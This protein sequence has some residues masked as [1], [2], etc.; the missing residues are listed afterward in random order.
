MAA[1]L[2]YLFFPLII[3]HTLPYVLF[4][5]LKFLH[6][7]MIYHAS[8]A[9]PRLSSVNSF[10]AYSPKNHCKH[11]LCQTKAAY[12]ESIK[13]PVCSLHTSSSTKHK[14]Q[15]AVILGPARSSLHTHVFQYTY[16]PYFLSTSSHELVKIITFVCEAANDL[17]PQSNAAGR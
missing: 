15:Q 17:L 6:C 9:D 2:F 14:C 1:I 16:F 8:C 11:L 10:A 12:A 4:M 3:H 7:K 5:L 13:N